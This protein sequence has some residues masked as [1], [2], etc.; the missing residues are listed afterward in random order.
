MSSFPLCERSQKNLDLSH[1]CRMVIFLCAISERVKLKSEILDFYWPKSS[2]ILISYFWN[3]RAV[4]AALINQVFWH[5][6]FRISSN[7][8]WQ[9]SSFWVCECTQK[10]LEFLHQCRMVIFLCAISERV[11]LKSEILDFYWPKSSHI[12]IS[13]FWNLRAVS[14]ALINQVFWHTFFRISSN[15]FWQK[16]SF[17]LCE[18]SQK[19]LDLSHQ[20]RMVIFLCAI[21]ER[22]K[23]KK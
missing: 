16:C 20:C 1:Q 2:H 3:L 19:N 7:F 12:L 14:A 22:V 10:N 15:F 4:S 18:R 9:M 21:S 13:Y 5:T 11:K 8:F 23:I 6:F 17:P